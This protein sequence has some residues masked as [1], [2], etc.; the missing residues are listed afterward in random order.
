MASDEEKQRRS[1]QVTTILLAAN[2]YK[3]H[4]I[5]KGLQKMAN[6]QEQALQQNQEMLAN[7]DRANIIA[8]TQLKF[9]L[10]QAQQIERTKLLKNTFKPSR[11]P[12]FFKPK[13]NGMHRTITILPVEDAL[14]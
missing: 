3:S 5:D 10:T 8:E 7:Q 11:P 13:P 6:L 14:V 12:K 9:Q 2:L 1:Q 4:K